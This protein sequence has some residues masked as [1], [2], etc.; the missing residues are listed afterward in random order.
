MQVNAINLNGGTFIPN[1][2]LKP[3]YQ[4]QYTVIIQEEDNPDLL[5]YDALRDQHL[6][7]CYDDKENVDINISDQDLEKFCQKKGIEKVYHI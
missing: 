4:K 6:V 2:E 5:D 1:I 3:H 7:K